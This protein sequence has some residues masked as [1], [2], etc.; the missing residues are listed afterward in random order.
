MKKLLWI[1]LTVILGNVHVAMAT[2]DHNH[3]GATDKVDFSFAGDGYFFKTSIDVNQ[4]GTFATLMNFTGRSKELGRV[5]AS[6]LTDIRVELDAN[7]I[8]KSCVTPDGFQ[9]IVVGLVKSK[10]I[11]QL[12]NG[13]QLFTEATSLSSCLSI[14]ECVDEQGKVKEGC[15]FQ[16]ITAAKI[17]GGTGKFTCAF[18]DSQHEHTRTVLAVDPQVDVFG[19]VSNFTMRGTVHIPRSCSK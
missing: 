10:G 12:K 7:G 5:S 3:G 15:A 9:G 17:I 19:S 4:D 13:D 11:I 8:P 2:Q 18:G 14:S 1:A 6:V 16:S